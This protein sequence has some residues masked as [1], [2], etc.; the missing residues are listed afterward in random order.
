MSTITK[1]GDRKYRARWRTPEGASR[2]K[3]FERKVDAESFLDSVGHSQ[4]VGTYIDS[5]ALRT[6]FGDYAAAWIARQPHRATTSASV[7]VIFR[8]H[9]T[10]T[11]GSRRLST[12]KTSEVQAWVTGLDLA[13]STVNVVYGK[14]AAVFRSAVEDRL[15]P[16]SP[17]TRSVKLP[18]AAG[19]RVVPMTPEQVAAMIGAVSGRYRALLVL[20]AGTGLRAGEAL[21]VT[22]D[23]VDFLRRQIRIDRQLV[24]SVGSAPTFGPCKTESSVRTIPVPDIVLAELGRHFEQ[25]GTDRTGCCSLTAR[26]T[27]SAVTLSATSGAVEPRRR[28][29]SG[30]HRTTFGT[31]QHP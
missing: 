16:Y 22:E 12:I 17:C 23:R 10:P 25:Y 8:K 9:I 3:T 13:P 28:V 15:I 19:A 30:S 21:G 26:A 20:L 6:T 29:L 5:A 1:V 18:R 24:T 27:R 2:S 11:F 31:T 14:L 4:Q 7:E